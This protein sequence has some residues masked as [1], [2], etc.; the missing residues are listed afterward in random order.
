MCGR[1]GGRGEGDSRIKNNDGGVLC[2]FQLGFQMRFWYLLGCVASKAGAFAVPFSVS[3]RKKNVSCQKPITRTCRSLRL[4]YIPV[5]AF[6]QTDLFQFSLIS[7]S[8]PHRNLSNQL[9]S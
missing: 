1:G 6:S 5:T 8:D 9:Q 2:T 3:S 4:S 7:N